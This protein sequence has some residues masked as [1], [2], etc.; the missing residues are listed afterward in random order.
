MSSGYSRRL[1]QAYYQRNFGINMPGQCFS[2]TYYSPYRM[3]FLDQRFDNDANTAEFLFQVD[4]STCAVSG[5]FC[6]DKHL[7]HLLLRTSKHASRSLPCPCMPLH[8][9][10]GHGAMPCTQYV[11][12]PFSCTQHQLAGP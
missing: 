2:S 9:C 11:A 4:V 6:C 10:G 1:L 8:C 3:Y 5:A 7:S 12:P